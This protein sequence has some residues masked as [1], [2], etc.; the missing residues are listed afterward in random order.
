MKKLI[1]TALCIVVCNQVQARP[2]PLMSGASATADSAGT[3]TQNPAGMTQFDS[4]QLRLDLYV[5]SSE[6]TWQ[7][8]LGDTGFSTRTTTDSDLIVPNVSLVKPLS[9]DWYFGFGMMGYSVSDDYGDD[10]I[11]KYAMTE[12]SLLFISAFPSIGYKINDKW[13][14]AGSLAANYT[15]YE[16]KKKVNNLEPGSPDG[17]LTIDADGFSLGYGFSTLYEFSERT[18]IGFNYQ[19]EL[20]PELD[21]DP[22]FSGL[23]T[24]TEDLFDQLGLLDADISIDTVSPQRA[25]VGIYHEFENRHAATFD[26]NWIDYSNFQLADIYVNDNQITESNFEYDDIWA[27]TLGYTFPLNDRWMLGFAGLYAPDM[28]DDD[29]RTITLRLDEIWAVGGG[30]EYQYRPNL[31][32][33]ATLSYVQVGDAP[34]ITDDIDAIGG[35][36]SGK[37]NDREMWIL[38]FGVEWGPGAD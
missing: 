26:I 24:T 2:Q 9:D 32:F 30:F 14:V 21:G 29:N 7:Q 22:D 16:Q 8:D 10:W 4:T 38:Q 11:G 27:Y 15:T 37:F 12:Y 3:V 25:N 19:S 35:P 1:F 18:R 23:D 36:I 13:S 5:L 17:D 34:V 31:S 28:V 6:S 33:D 20:D